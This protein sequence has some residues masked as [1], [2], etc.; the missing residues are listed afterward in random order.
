MDK[1]HIIQQL[2]E[3]MDFKYDYD[4]RKTIGVPRIY[5]LYVAY[6]KVYEIMAENKS[7][8]RTSIRFESAF[9]EDDEIVI[10]AL[11]SYDTTSLKLSHPGSIQI[12]KELVERKLGTWPAHSPLH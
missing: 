7:G 5:R 6:N 12:I 8:L 9:L 10:R 4:L 1:A 3:D 11:E 2:L